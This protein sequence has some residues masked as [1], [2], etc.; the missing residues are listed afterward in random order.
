[1]IEKGNDICPNCGG[2]LKYYDSVK[3]VVKSGYGRKRWIFID[4]YMCLCCGK[5]HRMLPDNLIPYKHYEKH[6]IEGFVSGKI[7]GYLLE[8]E[9]YPSESIINEWRRTQKLQHFL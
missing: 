5:T 6:I 9:D 4:R 8:F 2:A 7:T 1:M 3:R